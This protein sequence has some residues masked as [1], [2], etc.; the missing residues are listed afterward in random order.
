MASCLIILYIVLFITLSIAEQRDSRTVGI[1]ESVIRN[2]SFNRVILTDNGCF[3]VSD[4][5]SNTFQ[6]YMN[7]LGG[8]EKLFAPNN[9]IHL[10][11]ELRFWGEH[12]PE[13]KCHAAWLSQD[14]IKFQVTKLMYGAY[15]QTHY[16]ILTRVNSTT[17]RPGNSHCPKLVILVLEYLP[18][19]PQPSSP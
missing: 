4:P 10:S 19:C 9:T 16:D 13:D 7:Q 17:I 1:W 6:W 11:E 2:P 3:I 14:L 8:I 12:F 18:T 15:F 5:S